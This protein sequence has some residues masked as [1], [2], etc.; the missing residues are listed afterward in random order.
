MT[1]GVAPAPEVPAVASV[2]EPV[3]V[4]P[5]APEVQIDPAD[6]A[7]LEAATSAIIAVN[8]DGHAP[9]LTTA[10]VLWDGSTLRFITLG[11]ARRTTMLR[12]DPR[13]GVLIDGPDGRFLT[14]TGR[15]RIVEDRTVRDMAWPVLVRDTGDES[16][17]DSAWQALVADDADRAVVVIEPVQVL[18]GR[19]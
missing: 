17:A 1:P 19:R 4:A 16:A 2:P 6:R 9:Q 10:K 7:I 3:A 12:S 18:A 13:V 8:R 11:W 14:I 5:A 15:A